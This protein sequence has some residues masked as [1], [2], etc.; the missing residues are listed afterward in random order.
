MINT[1]VHEKSYLLKNY[2]KKKKIIIGNKINKV[3][4]GLHDCE[5]FVSWEVK[6][7]LITTEILLEKDQKSF[8]KNMKN[9]KKN[10]KFEKNDH[11]YYDLNKKGYNCPTKI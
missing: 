8:I 1:T 7:S 3:E 11:K 2:Y 10:K 9:I 6:F 5:K 4:K